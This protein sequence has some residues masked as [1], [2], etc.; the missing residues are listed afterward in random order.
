MKIYVKSPA[1]LHF[2]LIDMNG[3]MG[4]FFGGI[5][6]AIDKPN[7]ILEVQNSNIFSVTGEKRE[8]AEV[9]AKRFLEIYNIKSPVS[10]DVKQTIPEHEGFGSGTQLALAVSTALKT[11]F[12]LNVT[13]KELS[14][15]MRRM[16]RTGVGTV[17]FEKGGFVLDGGKRYKDGTIDHESVPPLIFQAPFPE[18]W[19]FVVSIP[20]IKKGLAMSAEKN[21]FKSI[22][23]MSSDVVGKICWLTMMKLLPSLLDC[24]IV[25]FGDAL[26]QIQRV[27]GNYFADIQGGT[28]S[29]LVSKKIIDFM[30]DNGASGV[31]QSSWGPAI[32]GLVKDKLQAAT[33]QSNVESFLQDNGGGRVF[34]AKANNQ[35]AII[36]QV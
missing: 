12:R 15:V 22:S 13:I 25:N 27:V 18:D 5:G 31:G 24:D 36:K 7:V 2:G 20:N 23:I 30:S 35:G 14:L 34:I 16:K 32:Y 9:F 28:F 3:G 29:S 17:V 8:L 10:I 19:R 21:A 33:L 4:R 1:R 6:V 11:L 26:T